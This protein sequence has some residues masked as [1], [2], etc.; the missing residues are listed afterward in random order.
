MLIKKPSLRDKLYG[1]VEDLPAVK[2]KKEGKSKNKKRK[3]CR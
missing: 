2:P 3:F 1:K